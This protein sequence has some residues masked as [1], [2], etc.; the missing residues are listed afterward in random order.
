MSLQEV[1]N[2]WIY[3]DRNTMIWRGPI[4]AAQGVFQPIHWVAQT[5][6]QAELR[7]APNEGRI[8]D[9]G[10]GYGIVTVN[11][12]WKKPRTEVIGIDPDDKRLEVGRQLLQEHRLKNCTF[13][14]GTLEET[15]IEP[16][17]CT[18]VICTELLDHL[19]EGKAKLQ[20]RIGKL[21]DLLQPG[22]R[23]LVSFLDP[24][25]FEYMGVKPPSPLTM[26]DFDW[27]KEKVVE[28]NCPR[29]WYMFYLDKR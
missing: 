15:G 5:R 18:G 14:T 4:Q 1:Q 17:S 20:E 2:A 23:L 22:G 6:M 24:E 8:A 11:L 25:G 21:M 7:L 19:P 16:G 13:R 28:R 10:C 3:L 29:W 26:S 27:L 9:V 12:A